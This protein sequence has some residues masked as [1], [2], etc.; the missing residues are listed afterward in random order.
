MRFFIASL[1]RDL[2]VHFRKP[3]EILNPLVFFIVVISLF[4]LG[5]GPSPEQLSSVAPAVVWVAALLAT[6]MSMDQMFSSDFEDGSLEQV[7]VSDQSLPVYVAAKIVVHWLLSGVPLVLLMPVIGLVLF[8]D[9]PGIWAMSIS[10][11]LVSPTLSLL[12]SIGAALTVGLP[13]GGLLVTILIMP[14]YVPVL[15]FATAMVQT[16]IGGGDVTG[17]V[18]WLLAILLLSLSLAPLAATAAVRISVDQ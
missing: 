18:Y 12:G 1:K 15:V 8:V 16:A 3:S 14:L 7:L 11:L 10:L 13:R 5:L 2:L 4:P 17:F 6:L 9:G